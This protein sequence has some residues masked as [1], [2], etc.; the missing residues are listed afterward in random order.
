VGRYSD[1]STNL[2]DF[3]KTLIGNGIHDLIAKGAY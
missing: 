3:K 2:A 1:N